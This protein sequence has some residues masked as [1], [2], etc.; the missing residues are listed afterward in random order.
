MASTLRP[1]IAVSLGDPAGIGPEVIAKWW[2]NRGPWGVAG[3]V[4]V[5][6]RFLGHVERCAVLIH[7]VDGTGED[8]AGAYRTIRGELG[9]YDP[10]LAEKPEIVVL[11]K[12]DA[13]SPQARSGRLR[14]L[15]RASGGEVLEVSAATHQGLD[16]VLYAVLD[17]LDAA[18]TER[19]ERARAKTQTA[20]AP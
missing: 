1:P 11:N 8:V 9:A 16:R 19:I 15:R 2:G 7:L 17:R 12:V 14:A 18:R 10:A 3:F 13:L 6:D 4:A 20:W 5:G